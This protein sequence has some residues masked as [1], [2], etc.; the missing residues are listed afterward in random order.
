[1]PKVSSASEDFY[2]PKL[3]F[4]DGWGG[5]KECRAVVFQYPPNRDSGEQFPEFLAARLLIQKYD[6]QGN[7]TDDEPLE[8]ILRI[9]KDLSR[10]RPG[11]AASRDDA[12]PSDLGAELGTEGN[13]VYGEE[14]AKIN[15]NS[16]WAVFTK[17]LEEHGFKASI[18]KESYFPDLEG[19]VFHAVTHKGEKRNIGGRDIEP[20]YFVV[21][22][23]TVYPYEQKAAKKPAG[24]AAATA[25]TKNGAVAP[26]TTA[27]P[28]PAAATTAANGAGSDPE[29]V[30]KS[31]LAELNRDLAGETRNA[32]QFSSMAYSRL[33]RNKARD[34]KHDKA[35]QELFKNDEFLIEQSGEIGFE[36]DGDTF[37]FSSPAAA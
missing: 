19:M 37:T 9:E 6:D 34:K 13:A 24:K 27:A 21:D 4:Q 10:M 16:A 20:N 7:P 30:A 14:G 33:V 26:A 15:T 36:Y 29:T 28:A 25:Q 11:Q 8:K 12:D 18:L 31:I 1:M 22:K 3:G 2:E 5:V 23:I 17:S 32:K 35:I